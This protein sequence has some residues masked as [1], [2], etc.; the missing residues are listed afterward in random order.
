MY[1]EMNVS[2]V[3]HHFKE[4]IFYLVMKSI[5]VAKLGALQYGTSLIILEKEIRRDAFTP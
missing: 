5:L 2:H 3:F 1:I 4:S